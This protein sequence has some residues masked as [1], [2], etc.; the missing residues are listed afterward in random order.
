MTKV[1]QCPRCAARGADRH[2]DNLAEYAESF[3]CFACGY[4][5][6]K[7]DIARVRRRFVENT[8][9]HDS[10]KLTD[11]S[12]ILPDVAINWL[13]KYKLTPDEIKQFKWHNLGLVLVNTDQFYQIR[14]FTEGM[15]KYLSKGKKPLTIY[16]SRAIIYESTIILVEDVI[17]SVKVSAVVDS[18]P[19]F[20]SNID[21]DKARELAKTYNTAVTWLDRDKA[22]HSIKQAGQLR[23]IFKNVYTIITD[24]DPKCYSTKEIKGKIDVIIKNRI[25]ENI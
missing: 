24:L 5:K 8:M 9:Q 14:S 10:V 20:G 25:K 13:M 21:K 6:Q 7:R 15:P 16:H 3:Y 2:R 4:Y 1:S 17:S 12:S 18:S 19:I 22:I 11:V 23:E